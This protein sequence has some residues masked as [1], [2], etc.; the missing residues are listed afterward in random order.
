MKRKTAVFVAL[1]S[2]LTEPAYAAKSYTFTKVVDNIR[3]NFN[4]NSFTC[5]SLNNHGDVAFKA[6][7]TASDGANFFDGIYR[8]NADG[9]LTTIVE[10][11]DRTTFGFL[12]NDLSMNNSG[13]VSFAA[14]LAPDF[15][16]A[17]L[18]RDGGA[19]TTIASTTAVFN[20][21]GF[22]TSVNDS[23]EVAFKGELDDNS[24]GLFSGSGGP[25]TT[26][27]VNNADISLDGNPA[28]FSG[29]DSRPSINNLGDIAFDEFV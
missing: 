6:T 19:L 15:E 26:H 22:D 12:S 20:L 28:R 25:L 9:T 29:N 18:L 24:E 21:F 16:E 8:A 14:N 4:V 23:G 5:A 10:D 7:R 17:I 27:Y 13:D 11:P 1:L 3:D 2:I